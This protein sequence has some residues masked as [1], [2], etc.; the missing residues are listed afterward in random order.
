MNVDIGTL[1]YTDYE[2]KIISAYGII[3]KTNW[4]LVVSAYENEIM[5]PVHS[6]TN[7]IILIALIVIATC[8]IFAFI[9][10]RFLIK[11]IIRAKE[12]V[13]KTSKLDLTE[14]KVNY[15]KFSKDEIGQI[16][17]SVVQM[18]RALRDV[19]KKIIDV[20]EMIN[21]NAEVVEKIYSYT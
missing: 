17:K 6:M 9:V 12:L 18:R 20:E 10:A 2:D 7:T 11:P 19:V 1:E 21:R 4:T 14:D 3:P 16:S 13:V 15:S 5:A 8:L